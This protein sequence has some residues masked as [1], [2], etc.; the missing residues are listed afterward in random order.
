MV[1]SILGHQLAAAVP[2]PSNM[3]TVYLSECVNLLQWQDL[4]AYY[5]YKKSGQPG[6]FT[7]ILSCGKEQAKAM[8]KVCN[9]AA[10]M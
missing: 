6:P 10:H 8:P 2:H 4:V 9:A 3:H 1:L 5:A 7:R